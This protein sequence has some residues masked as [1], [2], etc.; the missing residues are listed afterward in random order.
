M[1]DRNA[2]RG[3]IDRIILAADQAL[4]PDA[5]SLRRQA[6]PP[7]AEPAPFEAATGL[8]GKA[9]PSDAKPGPTTKH[10][11]RRQQPRAGEERYRTR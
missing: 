5:L 6:N 1:S 7:T 3:F 10:E 8:A 9:Y 11:E 4:P 2:F